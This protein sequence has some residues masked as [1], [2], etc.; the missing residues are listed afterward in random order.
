MAWFIHGFIHGW[1][2]DSFIHSHVARDVYIFMLIL[3]R[4]LSWVGNSLIF[5]RSS[6][7]SICHAASWSSSWSTP[8]ATPSLYA[9]CRWKTAEI[10]LAFSEFDRKIRLFVHCWNKWVGSSFFINMFNLR[11]SV[12]PSQLK[13]DVLQITGIGQGRFQ[14]NL[15][16]QDCFASGPILHKIRLIRSADSECL[17][18]WFPQSFLCNFQLRITSFRKKWGDAVHNECC[19]PEV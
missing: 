7:A 18:P 4:N 8:A 17:R 15:S 16:C 13:T 5:D 11:L 9:S 3:K 10:P 19:I 1:S 2:H 6:S 14:S 12:Y